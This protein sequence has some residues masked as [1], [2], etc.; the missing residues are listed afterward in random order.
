MP[1]DKQQFRKTLS[2]FAAGV[3][4]VTTVGDDGTPSGLTATA[5]TSVSLQPPLVLVCIDK[6]AESLSPLQRAGIFAVNFLTAA[7]EELSQR[8]AVSGED[9]F[10][11]LN[12][13]SGVTGAPLLAGTLGYVECRTTDVRDAGDHFIFIGQVE[14]ADAGDGEPLLYFDGAYRTLAKR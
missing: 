9:K 5:F 1:I 6:K 4:V 2:H 10:G 8:F 12:T 11:G 3:T 14:A 13:R 7:Q